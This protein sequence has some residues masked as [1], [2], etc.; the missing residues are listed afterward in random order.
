MNS[1]AERSA[2][3]GINSRIPIDWHTHVWLPEHFGGKLKTPSGTPVERGAPEKSRQTMDE[4]VDRYVIVGLQTPWVH[5][6]ND[7]IADQVAEARGK[8]VGLAS[9]NPVEEGAAREVERSIVKLGLHGLKISP[10]YQ[11]FDPRD[12]RARPVYDIANQLGIPIM[13]HIGGAGEQ[14]ATLE[15]GSPSLLDPIARAFP[16]L[17]MIIA[18]LG[19][20]FMEETVI[21]MRKHEFIFAD[22][23]AR[24][25]RPWQLYNGLIVAKEYGV[26]NKILFGTDFP[27]ATPRGALEM[28]KGLTKLT[29]GTNL[30]H[31][32]PE[33]I[34]SIVYERPFSL[35]GFE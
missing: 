1:S 33:M 31:V 28:F 17:K 30:P 19:Q 9:V 4:S 18:H 12:E 24:F 7:F 21:L 27:L 35:L 2:T 29:E 32:T 3:A 22:L 16:K 8:A 5:I 13:L 11:G 34:D 23:S 20:P 14:S 6:P 26:L 15:N 10:T 25:H